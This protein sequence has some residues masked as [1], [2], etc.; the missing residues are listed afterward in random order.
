MKFPQE[1]PH[2]TSLRQCLPFIPSSA[3]LYPVLFPLLSVLMEAYQGMICT[4][5]LVLGPILSLLI[6]TPLLFSGFFLS[7]FKPA[8]LSPILKH[9]KN[10]NNYYENNQSSKETTNGPPSLAAGF[11]H[12]SS[13]FPTLSV[14]SRRSKTYPY[15]L[16]FL[17]LYLLSDL[18]LPRFWPH[19]LHRNCFFP[20]KTPPS[21]SLDDQWM[22]FKA[23]LP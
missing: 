2:A 16:H 10:K 4:F 11:N 13:P 12:L 9:L 20:A 23:D 7:E 19:T 5:G 14:R 22:C 17:Y 18:L 6:H 8:Q 3:W 1:S 15:F 21:F